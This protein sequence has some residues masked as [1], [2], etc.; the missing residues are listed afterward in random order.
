MVRERI[1]GYT[2]FRGKSFMRKWK[3]QISRWKFDRKMQML[4]I[5]SITFTTLIVLIVSTVSSVTSLKAKS[6]EL[7]QDKNATLA[8]NY[9]NMLEEY[10]ALSLALVIDHSVQRYLECAGKQNQEYMLASSEA[11]NVLSSSLNMSSDLN[12]IAVISYQMDDYLYRGKIAIVTDFLQVCQKDLEQSQNGQK[13]TLKVGFSNAYFKGEQYTVNVYFPIYSVEKVMQE[14]GLLCLNYSNPILN[15]IIHEEEAGQRTEIVSTDGTVIA[16]GDT[17]KIGTVVDYMD[18]LKGEQ[19][20]FHQNGRIYI[21]QKVHKWNYYIISSIASIE[22]YRPSIRTIGLMI[23]ILLILIF[24]SYMI[25]KKV[26]QVAYE[27]LDRVVQKM[28]DVAAGTLTARIDAGYMGED[29]IKLATGFN[30]MMEEIGVLMEQVKQEQHQIEQIRFNA[31]QSQIKPHFL[32][33]TLDCIHWQAVVDGNDEISTLVKALARYYRICL[34][35]G[36]DVI[37]LEMEMEHVRNYMIIQNMRYDHIIGSEIHIREECKGAMIPKLTLQPLVENSIYHGI[38]VE[39]GK[40]GSISLSAVR[41]EDMV[42]I[43]LADTGTGMTQGQID[44]MNQHLSEYDES[45]GYGV[46]NVNKR[47]E[48]LY[49]RGYGLHYLKNALGG[50]T[51]EIR[52]PYV[53]EVKEE[54]MQGAMINV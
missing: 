30:S 14:R 22:L 43:T 46:R 11:F 6:I 52:I 4:I 28:D 27:P 19:G 24:V 51:V 36:R 45:F 18:Q 41:R 3:E 8:E 31:L 2:L 7:L 5:L 21:Y 10:K 44:E 1:L 17:G 23:W 15:Q 16:V 29:F 13:S 34:S 39:E 33:N 37:P 20:S 49:G 42:E 12:F 53:T 9:R 38:K 40:E 50:V 32:Y 35:K 25:V 47:I 48:L 54:M 26:I